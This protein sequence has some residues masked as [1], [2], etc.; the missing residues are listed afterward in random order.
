MHPYEIT[1]AWQEIFNLNLL[2]QKINVTSRRI[3]YYNTELKNKL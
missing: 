3:A 1:L 2:I